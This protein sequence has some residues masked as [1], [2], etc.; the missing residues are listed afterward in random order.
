VCFALTV[1]DC[2]TAAVIFPFF[3]S[4]WLLA[5][6]NYAIARMGNCIIMELMNNGN[7]NVDFC[8]VSRLGL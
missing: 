7:T 1:V 3:Q 8:V 5:V 2:L 4:C 6:A